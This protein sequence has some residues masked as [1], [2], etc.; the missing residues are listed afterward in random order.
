M[1]VSNKLEEATQSLDTAYPLIMKTGSEVWL[2]DFYHISG[3]IELK[4]DDF[5]AALDLLEKAWDIAERNPRGINQNRVLFDLVRAEIA[6][7][8]QSKEK[9]MNG[10]PGRWLSALEKYAY[11]RDLPGIRMYAALLKSEFYQAHEQLKDAHTTLIDAL[12]ISDSL[13]VKTLRQKIKS[14]IK[15]LMQLIQEKKVS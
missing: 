8:S 1:A 7:G 13:G 4:R 12:S 5:Q 6:L 3:L 14:R 10:T 9:I 2:G 15:E 11:V